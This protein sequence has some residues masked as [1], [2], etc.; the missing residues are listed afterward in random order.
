MDKM[1]SVDNESDPPGSRPQ[2]TRPADNRSTTKLLVGVPLL[3]VALAATATTWAIHPPA[4]LSPLEALLLLGLTGVVGGSR[5]WA[6]RI[7]K[8][9]RLYITSVPL[10][11]LCCLFSPALAATAIGIGMLARE[12]SVC[13]ECANTAGT[14]AAQVGRWIL[15]GL[16]VSAMVSLWPGE[17]IGYAALLALA[18][19]WLGDVLT[20]PFVF[21]PVSGQDPLVTAM[22][23][24]RQSFT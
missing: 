5:L 14:I 1:V 21:T 11:L 24:A 7:G 6:V 13:K 10:Y 17:Y 16:G 19:L 12:I 20:F 15:L 22:T 4:A 23:A 18:L 2:V 8:A 3:I 9:T